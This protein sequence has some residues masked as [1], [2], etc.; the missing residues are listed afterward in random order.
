MKIIKNNTT[1][2]WNVQGSTETFRT[3]KEA[4]EFVKSQKE[5][6]SEV[7]ISGFKAFNSD[8]TCR[9]FQYSEGETFIH[10]GTVDRCKSGFHFCENPID[11]FAYYDPTA[12][13]HRVEGSGEI[14]KEENGDSKVASQ[15]L[16][17]GA[18][19]SIKEI[20]D[21]T[22]KYISKDLDWSNPENHSTGNYSASSSTGYN[23]TSSAEG[24][25]SV[26]VCTG[27]KSKAKAGKYG[28][29]VLTFFDTLIKT[30][31]TK[32]SDIGCG[33]G[34]DGLLK[35]D[36]WYILDDNGNFEEITND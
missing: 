26:A 31:R 16:K 1:G 22:I 5:T 13:F 29:I 20:V 15:I 11:M 8:M 33:D 34:S 36:T 18:K 6:K 24:D 4:R 10:E 30:Y 2:S 7:V 35:A 25:C 28:S 23:S 21:E 14:S 12:T 32:S 19:L 27:I 9:G 17:I 3:R